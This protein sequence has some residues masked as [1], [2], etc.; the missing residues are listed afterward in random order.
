M[1]RKSD[2]KIGMAVIQVSQRHSAILVLGLLVMFSSGCAL[3]EVRGRSSFGPEY[4]NHSQAQTNDI[5]FE[6]K[7]GIEFRWDKG[8]TTGV[9]YRRRDIDDGNGDNENLIL[10]EIGYPIW[11]APKSE[12][13]LAQ[14]VAELERQLAEM[15]SRSTERSGI[16]DHSDQEPSPHVVPMR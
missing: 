3:K 8:I 15:R 11:S 7:Q 4:R 2:A 1:R 14:R 12:D 6:A 5:R 9:S 10:F 16:A 13:K